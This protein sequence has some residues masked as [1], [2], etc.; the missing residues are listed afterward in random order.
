[1][2]RYPPA[3][4]RLARARRARQQDAAPGRVRGLAAGHS[5]DMVLYRLRPREQA[6]SQGWDLCVVIAGQRGPRRHRPADER[7]P[8]RSPAGHRP[9]T[10]PSSASWTLQAADE[11]RQDRRRTTQDDRPGLDAPSPSP[12][13]GHPAIAA[14][15]ASQENEPGARCHWAISPYRP[16]VNR[17]ACNAA[18]VPGGHSPAAI[19]AWNRPVS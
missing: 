8:R 1:M 18:S 19:P 16:A 5:T 2:A 10:A 13:A 3:G 11:G 14:A 15:A 12:G 6:R 17:R 7:A 9:Q 4:R